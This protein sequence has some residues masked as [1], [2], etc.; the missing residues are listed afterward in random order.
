M[1]TV[2]TTSWEFEWRN[3][4]GVRRQSEAARALLIFFLLEIS[5]AVSPYALPP[6]SKAQIDQTEVCAT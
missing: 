2:V 4:Y 3:F 1:W 6:H 5:K